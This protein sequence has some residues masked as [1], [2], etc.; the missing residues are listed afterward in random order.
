M[1]LCAEPCMAGEYSARQRPKLEPHDS[2]IKRSEGLV[3]YSKRAPP[4]IE[5]HYCGWITT[6]PLKGKLP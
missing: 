5:S 1:S 2:M 4:G 3:A 6:D